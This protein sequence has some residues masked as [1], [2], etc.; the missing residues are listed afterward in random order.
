MMGRKVEGEHQG[1]YV[2]HVQASA[3]R[4]FRAKAL[5]LGLTQTEALEV[6][7]AEWTKEKDSG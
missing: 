4:A 6:M 1:V 7:I 5:S 3:W 2:R